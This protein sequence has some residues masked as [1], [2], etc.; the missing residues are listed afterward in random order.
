[1]TRKQIILGHYLGGVNHSTVWSDPAAGSQIDFAS[2]VHA[3][4]AAERGK[5]DFFFLAEGLA[6]RERDGQIFDQDVIGRPDAITVLTALAAVTEHLGLVATVNATFNEPYE[7]ARQLATLD[8]LSGGRAGWNIVTSSD[9]F[10]GGNFRRGGFLKRED[11]YVRA[12]EFLAVARQ[13]WDSWNPD[14]IVAD[15]ASGTFLRRPDAGAFDFAGKQF[16]VNG[17]FTTPRSPQGQPVIL[18]AG[19]SSEGREF[20][21]GGGPD[22]IFSPYHTL[23][24]AQAFYRDIQQ[25]A[26]PYGR[27]PKILPGASFVLGDTLAEAEERHREISRAQITGRGAQILLETVWNRDLSGF[28]PDGPL[29][30]VDPTPDAPLFIQGRAR[31]HPDPFATVAEWRAI[32]EAN[33]YS[34]RDLAI[35]VFSRTE[36]IGTPT[37]VADRL[38][39]FVQNDGS[40][41]FIIGSHLTPTGID[42]FV[43][44]VV[45][46]LQERGSLRTDYEGSTLRD[47]LGLTVS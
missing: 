44:K 42:E 33:K 9:A 2:F 5:F 16:T 26:A 21:A 30:D 4:Q 14:D 23:A 19:I 39:A 11:R 18:Q 45:P 22:A 10:T 12:E 34:L 28:D 36:F 13:L 37:Q 41:G 38:D 7:L 20:A 6:L 47:N 29:P 8:H 25:R 15:Q 27:A 46:L 32:A 3:A 24:E 31:I 17:R 35:H 1:M 40:D 43:D